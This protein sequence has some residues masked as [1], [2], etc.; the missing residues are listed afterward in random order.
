MRKP[1]LMSAALLALALGLVGCSSGSDDASQPAPDS[2]P[3]ATESS[4]DTPA[5]NEAD[6]AVGPDDDAGGSAADDEGGTSADAAVDR[7][8]LPWNDEVPAEFPLEDIPLPPTG[9][10]DYAELVED[11]V[12]NV[13]ISEIPN[14]D[15]EAWIETMGTFFNQQDDDGLYYMG[16]APSGIFYSINAMVFDK[17]DDTVT[18]AY[19]ISIV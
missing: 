6:D 4:D 1:V 9:T 13:M 19:R 11:D 3:A 10:M 18:M 5:G 2:Q 8:T 17:T 12:W 7:S 15:H 16:N 14:A